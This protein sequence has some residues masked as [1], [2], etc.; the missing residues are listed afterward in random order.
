MKTVNK[1][2]LK[3]QCKERGGEDN[4]VILIL[5]H[6]NLGLRP[7]LTLQD[8]I[9]L[10]QQTIFVSPNTKFQQP[11]SNP[12]RLHT[13]PVLDQLYH[14]LQP[15]SSTCWTFNNKESMFQM[16]KYK[17][18]LTKIFHS[19]NYNISLLSLY[20]S[21]ITSFYR[22]EPLSNERV[23]ATMPYFSHRDIG[24]S[25]SLLE[26]FNLTSRCSLVTS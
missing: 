20:L 4:V 2:Q 15:F 7:A 21:Q 25:F 22:S 19:G 23:E 1:S 16:H 12:T 26:G 13:Q 24:S 18:H 9:S 17:F 10:T 11:T 14:W 8:Q 3:N 5:V 6:P